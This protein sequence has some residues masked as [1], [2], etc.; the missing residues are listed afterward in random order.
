[1]GRRACLLPLL[2]SIVANVAAID[3][4][5]FLR[6]DVIEKDVAII[7]GGASG[8][9]AAVR[10][11]EDY[12]ASIV[13]VERDDH[14]SGHVNTHTIPGTNTSI[15]YGVQS[16][17]RYGGAEDFFRRMGV[18]LDPRGYSPRRSTNINLDVETGKA[19]A[20]F[21]TPSSNE[22]NAALDRWREFTKKY[23]RFMDPG[24]WDFPPPDA[25]PEELLLP[26]GEIAQKYK[27]EPAMIRITNIAG[28]GQGGVRDL[29]TLN[30]VAAFG[31]PVAEG[32]KNGFIAPLG[33]NSVL[34]QRAY[35][36]LKNDVLLSSQ[37]VEGERSESG[38]R[39]VVQSTDGTKKL[40][41]AKR[42]LISAQPSL[43]NMQPFDLDEAE[44][45]V[46]STWA[47][48]GTLV[49]IA[50]I[51]C[52]NE[53]NS[54]TFLPKAVVPNNYL[55]VKDYPYQLRFDSTGPVG[56]KLFRVFWTAKDPMP[57]DETKKA[58]ASTFQRAI[59]AG[60]L[61]TTG[62]CEISYKAASDHNAIIW[63]N[64][65][66]LIKSGFVQRLYGLQG[67]RATWYTGW[68]WTA[69]YSSNVWAYT[70]TVLPRL[71][72]GLKAAV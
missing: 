22:T 60:T 5:S 26:F 21:I 65:V 28:V 61:N 68:S 46:Y 11:R 24:Y 35:D 43:E 67:K 37:I 13:L 52:I 23:T 64:D 56:S 8:T 57:V 32:V 27:I 51:P 62:T 29:M 42:L 44:T 54:L 66:G 50:E 9:Y 20:G 55:A 72:K 47:R 71:L 33:S 36:L 63:K 70:D 31:Y 19:L 7:G 49:G 53:N 30:M 59:D 10:L 48:S 58:I 18:E 14:L 41:K 2:S 1:M 39:L 38:V 17:M 34:Y 3:K 15:N 45:D 25:I 40:I 16:Y 12:N 6:D 69:H 4:G